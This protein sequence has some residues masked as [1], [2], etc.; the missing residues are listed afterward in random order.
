ML[1]SSNIKG[2]LDGGYQKKIN[3]SDII[4]TLQ[5]RGER[6]SGFFSS[7]IRKPGTFPGC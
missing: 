2:E 4:A 7:F 3:A 1:S 6:E 5:L